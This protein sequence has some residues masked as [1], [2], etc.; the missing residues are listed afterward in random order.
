MVT[1]PKTHDVAQASPEPTV[2]DPALLPLQDWDRDV[3]ARMERM[4]REMDRIF[5][6]SFKEFRLVPE[7]KGIFD[8]SRFGSSVD[9]QEEGNNYVVR[10]CLPD[11][12]TKNVNVTVDG[13]TLKIEAKA[14]ETD[15][16]QEKG[17]IISHK[18]QYSQWLTLPGPVKIDKMQVERKEGM[19]LV[20]LPKA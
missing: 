12:D 14:D 18:A 4:R 17:A 3:L 16:K 6:E 13:Q 19:I 9:L 5:D 10:A 11:R 20:T 8:Q 7:Y 15:K 2:P 1:V